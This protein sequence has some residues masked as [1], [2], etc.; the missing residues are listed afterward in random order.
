MTERQ[1]RGIEG[2]TLIELLVVILIVGILATVALPTL[3]GQ[4]HKAYDASAKQLVTSAQTAAETIGTDH[5]GLYGEGATSFVTPQAIHEYEPTIPLNS[6]QS[7]GGSWLY[8]AQAIE[9]GKGYEVTA[10]APKNE[11]ER[12]TIRHLASGEVVRVC[13]PV[14]P[15]FGCTGSW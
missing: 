15:A 4:A 2:F 11:G 10:I 3:L 7:N 6:R 13:E 8:A 9:N 5:G 1:G 12:F 14:S